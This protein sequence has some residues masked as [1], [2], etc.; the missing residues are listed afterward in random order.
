MKDGPNGDGTMTGGWFDCGDHLKES[1][2]MSYATAMLGLLSAALP[3]SDAD[4]YGKNHN[5]TYLTDGVPDVLYETKM[6]PTST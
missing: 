2:S 1:M 4:H 6:G 3:D 5:D